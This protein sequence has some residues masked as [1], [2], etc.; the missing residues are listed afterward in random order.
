MVV[1]GEHGGEVRSE[2][3]F[4]INLLRSSAMV[5]FISAQTYDGVLHASRY[6]G[7][8]VRSSTMAANKV[9]F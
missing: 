9:G 7:V 8:S 5:R 6:S 1:P 3:T 4:C 2:L